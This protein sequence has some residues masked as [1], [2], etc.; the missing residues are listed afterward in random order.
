MVFPPFKQLDSREGEFEKAFK[1]GKY[2]CIGQDHTPL[3][4]GNYRELT[5]ACRGC[6]LDL[7]KR[8]APTFTCLAS[9]GMTM[10]TKLAGGFIPFILL[11]DVRS[12]NPFLKEFIEFRK[13]EGQKIIKN[14]SVAVW[15]M[16]DKKSQITLAVLVKSPQVVH[17]D[18][19]KLVLTAVKIC[20]HAY[21]EENYRK[22]QYYQGWA[23]FHFED[24]YEELASKVQMEGKISI[25]MLEQF[26]LEECQETIAYLPTRMKND[27]NIMEARALNNHLISI[28]DCFTFADE[29]FKYTMWDGH[30][31]EWKMA[32][33]QPHKG[34]SS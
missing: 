29:E 17:E 12:S 10:L 1:E 26:G 25:E 6:G 3:Y 20:I 14:T 2:I 24:E 31:V 7:I 23:N 18:V 32:E 13:G 33:Y 22:H 9:I 34:K 4:Q 21:L 27:L 28:N 19:K 8:L 11:R 15:E 16:L 30:E 5:F